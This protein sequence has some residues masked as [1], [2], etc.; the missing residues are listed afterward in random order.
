MK[1]ANIEKTRKM[2]IKRIAAERRAKVAKAVASY[3]A[4]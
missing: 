2:L 3:A 4:R 1:A